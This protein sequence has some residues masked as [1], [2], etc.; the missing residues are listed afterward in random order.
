MAMLVDGGWGEWTSENCSEPCGGGVLNST[1][2]CDNPVP[3]CGGSYCDGEEFEE[4]TCN[5]EPCEGMQVYIIGIMCV[6]V[7]VY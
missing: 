5:V 2:S 6:I 7:V 4:L 1:R 3:S